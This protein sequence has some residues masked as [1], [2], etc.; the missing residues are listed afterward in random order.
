ME[1]MPWGDEFDNIGP[2]NYEFAQITAPHNGT[3]TGP[4]PRDRDER[5]A[6]NGEGM[7]V[8]L[9]ISGFNTPSGR[10]HPPDRLLLSYPL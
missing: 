5:E 9:C 3:T 4:L 2:A 10:P 8:V 6:W 7:H 1:L